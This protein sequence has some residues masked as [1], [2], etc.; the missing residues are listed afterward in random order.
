MKVLIL[1][2]LP[3][4]GKSTWAKAYVEKN[5][6]WVRVCRDDLR[7]M[8]GTYWLPKQENLITEWERSLVKVALGAGKSVVLDATNLNP[9]FYEEF[10]KSITNKGIIFEDKWFTCDV[11]ECIKRDLKRPNSVGDKVIRQM[12]LRYSE[13]PKQYKGMPRK[14]KAVIFDIDG[15]LALNRCGRS[16]Y[17]WHR[18]GEDEVND[19]VKQVYT[20]LS[21]SGY[22][23][24]IVS[25]RDSVCKSLTEDWLHLKGISYDELLMRKEG[26]SEKDS[27]IKERIFWE[28][29]AP[30]YDVQ[31]VVDDRD[32]VVRFW[33]SI[34]LTC[35]Q[36]AEGDF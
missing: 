15:T 20:A 25:G 4:S 26:N 33:R 14:P 28:Q 1:R 32:Q 30:N 34:G 35:L 13:A 21:I 3:A 8:R 18:V 17:D 31:F 24:I 12:H 6:D 23:I 9:V 10:K 19:S 29:V 7:N 5:K 36:C 11:E 2:G 22:K 27:V 16:P